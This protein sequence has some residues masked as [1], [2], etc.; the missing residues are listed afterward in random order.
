MKLTEKYI[1]K[2]YFKPLTYGNIESLKLEDDVFFDPKK[3]IILSTDTY[4]E[5]IHF[6]NSADPAKFIKKIFRSSISDII[7]KGCAPFVYFLPLSIK[8]KNNKWFS[9][10]K[11][12]LSKDSKKFKLFLGGGDTI[13]SKINSFTF[14]ILGYPSKKPI[15]RSGAKIDDDI[16]ITGNLGD[17]YLG[18]LVLLKKINLNKQNKFFIKAFSEPDLPFKFSTKLHKFA[19]SSTDI[20]D[21][22]IIDLKNIC[23]ASKCGAIISFEKIPFSKN[24]ILANKLKQIRSIDIFSKGDDYQILFTAN[25]T[26]RSLIVSM[27]KMTSTKVSR[28]GKIIQKRLV[29]LSKDD[30]IVNLTTANTGYIHKF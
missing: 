19:N 4:E 14:T 21:G 9:K 7:C 5:K 23:K 18:L 6:L 12:E 16:Y 26:K 15:L 30:K 13:K 20:S 17:S 24:T 25:K 2:K 3:K 27:A 11:S 28:V 1:I 10:L 22:L 29:K 8:K